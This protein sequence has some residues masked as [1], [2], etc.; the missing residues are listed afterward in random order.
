MPLS[1]NLQ[2]A[3][4]PILAS[5]SSLIAR[6][7]HAEAETLVHTQK[8]R[9][10][11]GPGR[12]FLALRA[13]IALGLGRFAASLEWACDALKAA[14][15]VDDL[16]R[17]VETIRIRALLGLG[18]LREAEARIDA[19]LHLPG[20]QAA[21][22]SLFRAQL[23]FRRAR[24]AESREQVGAAVRFAISARRR[25]ALV[26]ALVLKARIERESG[27][28]TAARHDLDRAH[29]LSNG[30]RN[31]GALAEVLSDRAD[32]LAHAGMWVAA[33]KD[34]SQSGRLFARAFSPHEHLTAGRRTGLLDLATGDPHAALLPIERAA[35]ISR[36]GFGTP[37]CRAEID[38]LL[39]DAQ[40]AGKD[41]EGAL[42]R[43]TAALSFFRDSDDCAGRARAHVRRSLAALSASNAGLA[44]R[45]ASSAASIAGAESVAMGLAH[46]ALG[47]VLLRQD[48]SR[49]AELFG[50]A[51]RNPSLYPPLRTVA[52]LGVALANGV[53]ADSDCV[54]QH[55]DAIEAFGD[56][57]IFSMVRSDLQEIWGLEAGSPS[58][59]A[60]V[61]IAPSEVD[62]DDSAA[63]FLPG[64]VG[65]S[66]AVCRLAAVIR[67]AAP[68]DMAISIYGET[69]TGKEKIARAIHDLSSR[70]GRKFVAI[71]AAVLSDELFESEIFGHA[72]GAFTGAQ[73]D[74]PGLVEEAKGGTLFIDEVAELSP[75][76]QAR[77]LRVLQ[78]GAYR[79]VGEN[80]ERH[81]DVRVVVAANQRLDDLVSAGRF[82][83]DLMYRLQDLSVIVPPLHER[84][85]DILR[86]ARHFMSV[87]SQGAFRLSPRSEVE[88]MAYSWPGN[89]RELEQEIRRAVVLSDSKV[90]EWQ[91]PGPG[92]RQSAPPPARPAASDKAAGPSAGGPLRGALFSF[93]RTLLMSALDRGTE[94]SQV[95][96]A[97]GISRQALHQKMIR[98]GL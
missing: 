4:D 87:W 36:R 74:R 25:P 44:L 91:R 3:S 51:L 11:N 26:E 88:L 30:L 48:R 56:R 93:E 96:R 68:S 40:L 28:L 63:E 50:R 19:R 77:L 31:T 8:R 16:G 12:T 76:S 75:R 6:G 32:L 43:A 94:R 97:L 35:S 61:A 89:V 55:I 20:W 24:L 45:E 53:A 7:R 18:R 9:L 95:A 69:G 34:A 22:F 79:R 73:T 17:H 47:R 70:S 83:L 64:L 90:I 15:V 85:R 80:H 65:S 33:G 82:R 38:L 46:I 57:R 98:Y 2:I 71:N 14:E 67:R 27:D 52:H 5:L 10:L 42:D 62:L 21:E 41:P 60:E 37:E 72:R 84:G 81:A 58:P 59:L 54:R 49:A 1:R 92:P 23:A 86:L 39:A 13:E 78:D 66:D 29:R